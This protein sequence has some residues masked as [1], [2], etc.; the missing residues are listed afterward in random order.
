M[1]KVWSVS[2]LLRV[3]LQTCGFYK[4]N[5]KMLENYMQLYRSMCYCTIILCLN[6][7]TN[8]APIYIIYHHYTDISDRITIFYE[9]DQNVYI[10]IRLL[11][12]CI[13]GKRE[14]LNDYYCC[15]I[16]SSLGYWTRAFNSCPFYEMLSNSFLYMNP[17]KIFLESH[18]CLLYHMQ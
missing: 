8:F 10:F 15:I 4:N 1:L 5:T 3:Y 14:A 7:V 2:M 6:L 9:L 13:F 11:F 12:S 16:W 18:L 17:R